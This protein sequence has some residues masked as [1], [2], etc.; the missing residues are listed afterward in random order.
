[1]I[2]RIKGATHKIGDFGVG[3]NGST[4]LNIIILKSSMIK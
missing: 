4:N 2:K 1:M 3:V